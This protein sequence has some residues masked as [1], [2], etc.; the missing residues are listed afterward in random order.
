MKITRILML[1]SAFIGGIYITSEE[2]KQARKVLEKK[3]STFKP[4]IDDLLEQANKVLKGAK[5][6]KSSQIRTNIDR[7]VEEAKNTL[8]EIKLEKTI[9][10]IK[11]AISVSSKKIREAFNE[12]EKTPVKNINKK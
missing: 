7:L 4:I 8:V 12:L 5:T 11:Q 2:G 6:I 3:R 10:M 1:A 9:D